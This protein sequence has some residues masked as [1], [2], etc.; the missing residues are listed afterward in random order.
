MAK[1]K[2]KAYHA[3]GTMTAAEFKRRFLNKKAVARGTAA[4]EVR[5]KIAFL[6]GPLKA[7]A[8]D[9]QRLR[10]VNVKPYGQPGDF[11][12]PENIAAPLLRKGRNS[13]HIRTSI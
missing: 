4:V 8:K 10:D 2:D 3:N 9:K 12:R 1:P 13:S 7:T 5:S 11:H 6:S